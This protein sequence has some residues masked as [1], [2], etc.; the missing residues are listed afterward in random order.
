MRGMRWAMQL[1]GEFR[2]SAFHCAHVPRWAP[3]LQL[4]CELF[5]WMYRK[6]MYADTQDVFVRR[7][8]FTTF[9]FFN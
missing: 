4:Y 3:S 6:A 8:F 7:N 5:Y 1:P 9:N 2:E